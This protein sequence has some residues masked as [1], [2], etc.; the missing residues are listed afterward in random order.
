LERLK[1]GAQRVGPSERSRHGRLASHGVG[2]DR[3]GF[4]EAIRGQE[5]P[6]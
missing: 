3:T 5:D 6:D 4:T 1:D 2:G